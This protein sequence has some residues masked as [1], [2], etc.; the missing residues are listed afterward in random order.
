MDQKVL[1]VDD[2]SFIRTILKKQLD[3]LEEITTLEATNGNE[4]L[5]KAKVTKPAVILL[6]IIM[7]NK[8]GIQTLE[9]LK[10]NDRTKDI[11]VIVIS[12]HAEEEK[13]NKVMELGAVMFID[14]ADLQ[15]VNLIEIIKK[16]L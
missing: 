5:G 6:D 1:I 8:D 12:S 16:Y 9:E 4:A 2:Q 13:I 7:P 11:P 15:K 10:Q 3:T 14:K